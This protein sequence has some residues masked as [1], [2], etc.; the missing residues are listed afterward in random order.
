MRPIYT[1]R[2]LWARWQ[3]HRIQA[4]FARRE[5]EAERRRC[6]RDLGAVRKERYDAVHRMLAR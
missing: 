5:R 2:L 3:F 1:L 4:D 6:T